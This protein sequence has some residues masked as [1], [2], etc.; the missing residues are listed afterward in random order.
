M[1]SY[2]VAQARLKERARKPKSMTKPAASKPSVDGPE[3]RTPTGPAH[4][5]YASTLDIAPG[6]ELAIA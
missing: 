3:R 2:F 4:I 5:E 6:L 1:T